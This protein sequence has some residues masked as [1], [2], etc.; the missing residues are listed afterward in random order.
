MQGNW[1]IL[2]PQ[3]TKKQGKRDI[4]P[5]ELDDSVVDKID[6]REVFDHI[7]GICDPEHPEL[8]LEELHV[9]E[10]GLITVKLVVF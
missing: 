8:T 3:S 6:S 4:L 10:E 7:S 9:I 2:V 1:T 5:K